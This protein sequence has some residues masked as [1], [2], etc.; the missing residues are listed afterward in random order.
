MIVHDLSL[1]PLIISASRNA[2]TLDELQA[3]SNDWTNWLDK[4]QRFA[5]LRIHLDVQS[6]SHPQGGAKEKKRWFSESKQSLQDL[7]ISMA[8]IV[9]E[10]ILNDVKR[11]NAEKLYAVPADAFGNNQ[12]AIEWTVTQ[13]AQNGVTVDPKTVNTKLTALIAS[14]G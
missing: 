3:F 11:M 14:L 7:V 13:L 6:H 10:E 9:P 1:W 5:T 12:K 2:P 8:T 4:G